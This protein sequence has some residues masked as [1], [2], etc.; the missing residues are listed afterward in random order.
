LLTAS[1]QIPFALAIARSLEAAAR[2]SG[3]HLLVASSDLEGTRTLD[4]AA[5]LLQSGVE[6][7]IVFN[8]IENFSPQIAERCARAGVPVVAITFPLPG[9]TTFGVDSYRAGL[10][11][12]EGF[13]EYVARCWP[14]GPD[15]VVLLD[16]A[17]SGQPRQARMAGMMDGLSRVI[18]SIRDAV[19]P[20]PARR[21]DD[22][23]RR[24][25]ARL[26]RARPGERV[27]VLATNDTYALG[28]L[29][30]VKDWGR[31]ETVRILGQGGVP[32]VRRELQRPASPLWGTVAHFPEQF[33]RK[34][35][36]VALGILQGADV[37]A[38]VYT[39]H[40]LLTRSNL[41]R[42][43]RGFGI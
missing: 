25:L 10:D 17:D 11:G 28:A 12:G 4:N 36:P 7:M 9:A 8:P 13:G 41:S 33:G 27:V 37:G 38:F 21:S 15:R 16:S 39:E 43:Y 22:E 24:M 23:P 6:L 2:E 5:Q 18:P 20:V 29:S 42:Y 1:L 30:A 14:A 19:A 26:L 35:M 3:V 32:E 40:A 34:L 31:Q